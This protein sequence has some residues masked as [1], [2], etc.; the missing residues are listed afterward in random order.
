MKVIVCGAGQ[1][2]YNIAKSLAE[3][4][5]DVTVLDRSEALVKKIS[6]QLDVKGVVG[7][8][9]HP[10][11]LEEAGAGEAE[12]L[13]AVTQSDEV[14]M[15]ACQVAHSL[16][17]I[18]K[19][20][21]RIRTQAY[22]EPQY[23]DIFARD[24]IPID[25]IISPEYEVARA[26]LY[27]M[28]V[29]GAF[30]VVPFAGDK[31]RVVGIHID[32]HCPIIDTPLRQLTE[33]FPDLNVVVV[34]I[35]REENLIVPTGGDQRLVG[36]D[37]YIV[38][39]R[40]HVQR[41]LVIF[42]HEEKE[43]RRIVIVGG[44]SVGLFLAR[45]LEDSYANV[46]LKV[47]E[48]DANRA[49]MVANEVKRSIVIIGDAL[50][51]GLRREA[52]VQDAETVVAVTND[53]KVN[54]LASLLA[55]N[56]GAQKAVTLINNPDYGP[57]IASLGIDVSIDPRETTVSTIMRHVR[58]GRI[59]GLHT[60]GSGQAEVI[61]MQAM[62]TSGI[63]GKPLRDLHLPAGVLIGAIIRDGKTVLPRGHTVIAPDDHVVIF[64]RGDVVRK[65]ER[66]FAVGLEFF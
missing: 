39:D 64:A 56:E 42:G 34:G 7:F 52:N 6:D 61:E 5:I 59:R 17:D 47:I 41:T 63:V 3:E 48:R 33:L 19:K 18:P 9:S 54:I 26:V 2:G 62:A 49:E 60:L 10:Q 16:F 23:I 58:R 12:M 11:S 20:I 66:L 32:E 51:S 29:P 43:A 24:K 40:D 15:T 4:G 21:A 37:V 14:N 22:L 50:D 35:V 55:K 38:A 8:A 1:V 46:R 53:D 28:S 27:R 44:G 25:V 13:I 45:M 57:L 30:D 31:V 65:V 36:D